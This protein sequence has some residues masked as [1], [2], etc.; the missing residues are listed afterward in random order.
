MATL[1]ANL[2]PTVEVRPAFEDGI[3]QNTSAL[4]CFT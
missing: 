4:A 2:D 3:V 1:P